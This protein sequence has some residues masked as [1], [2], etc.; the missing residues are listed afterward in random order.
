MADSYLQ[1]PVIFFKK[2]RILLRYCPGA[3]IIYL[4]IVDD[5]AVSL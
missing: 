1:E 3:G 4:M 5:Q 2:T